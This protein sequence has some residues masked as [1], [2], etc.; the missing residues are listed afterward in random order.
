MDANSRFQVLLIAAVARMP[1]D[2]ESVTD[3]GCVNS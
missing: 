3:R 1:S 2:A